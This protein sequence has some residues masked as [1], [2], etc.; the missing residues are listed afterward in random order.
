MRRNTPPGGA[1]IDHEWFPDA[2]SPEACAAQAALDERR[3][4]RGARLL[5]R[6]ERER[7][8]WLEDDEIEESGPGSFVP[9]RP[10][11]A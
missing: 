2:S 1:W 9:S 10:I 6:I 7:G 3:R 5:A 8:G 11:R 4:V